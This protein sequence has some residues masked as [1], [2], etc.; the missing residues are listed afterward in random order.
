MPVMDGIEATKKIRNWEKQEQI[1]KK[2]QIIAMTANIVKSEI[3]R[4]LISGM[5]DYLPKPYKPE[6]LLS[7]LNQYY[8]N[9]GN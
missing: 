9:K 6:A 1:Q 4:C 5:D 8:F 7:K 2:T 3:E